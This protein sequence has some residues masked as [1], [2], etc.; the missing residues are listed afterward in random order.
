MKKFLREVILLLSCYLP[1]KLSQKWQ[2]AIRLTALLSLSD[3]ALRKL[4]L[5]IAAFTILSLSSVNSFAQQWTILGNES[6]ISSDASSYTSIAVLDNIPF[7]VYRDTGPVVKVK[8]RNTSTGAWEQLGDNIGAN[9]TYTRIYLDKTNN[10]YVTYVDAANGNKLA[11][12][13]YNA[14]T[15]IWEPLNSDPNQLYVSTGSVTSTVSQYSSTQRSSLAFD[16]D[17]NP[18]IAFGEGAEL[19]PYVKKFNGTSWVTVG[20]GSVDA[21]AKIV[22]PSLVIDEAD[23]QWLAFSSLSSAT[24]STGNLALY[25]FNRGTWEPVPSTVTSIR[26]TTMAFNSSG[27][28]TIAYF[29]TGNSNKATIIVYN[30]A[31]NTWSSATAL[32]SRD[33]P[34][35]NLIRDV[36]GNLY[37]SFVDAISTAFS[38]VARVF[39]QA[40]GSSTWTELRDPA[41]TRGIDEPTSALTIAAGTEN[42]YIVYTKS[43]SIAISTPIVRI[44]TPPAAPA[45][46]TTKALSAITTSS[47]VTAVDITSDG[48][49]PITERGVVYGTSANPT[50]ANSKIADLSGGTGSFN[51]SITGLAP[52]TL[53]YVRGYAINNGN[54]TYGNTLRLNTLAVPDAVVTTARQMEYLTRGLVA[55]RKTTSQVFVSWRMLGTDPSNIAFN[56]YRDDIKLNASPITTST[57]YLDNVPTN[58]VYIVKPVINGVEGAPSAPVSVWSKNQLSIPMQIPAGGTTFDGVAYTY[59]AND[60]SVGDVDGDGEYEIFVK[61]DPTKLNHNSGGYS[62][63]QIIDCYKLDGTRLWRINLGKNINAGP[64]FTQFMVYDLDGDGKAEMVCKTA[65]GTVDGTGVVIGNATV[66]YRNSNG[67]VQQGPEFL[68]VFNGLTGVAMA[69]TTYQPARGQVTDWGDN[70]GNRQDRFVSAIAYLDGARPSLI[71]GRGYYDKLVR[72]AYDWRNG[73][74]TLRWIFDSKDPNNPANEAYSGQGNHQ[75]TIGDVDGDGKDEVINGSSAINDDGKRLWTYGLG[76]GDALH[77]TDM[78]P[79]RP[80]QEIWINLESPGQYASLGLRQYDAKTGQTIWGV[81]TTGDVGRSLAA[82]IDPSRRGYEMW[83][84]S[85]NLYDVKGNEISTNKPSYNFGIWWDGDLARELLEGNVMDKW[86]YLTNS[87]GRLLTIYNDAPVSSNNDTK[88]TPCLTA[89]LMGDWREEMILRRSDNTALI[90]FTTNIL[91][92]HRIHTLMHDPQYRTAVAWQNSGYNQPPYPSFY[93]G[94]DMAA[95]PAPNIAIKAIVQQTI[96]FPVI[97]AKFVGDTDF[98]PGATAGSGLP[99]TYTSSDPIVATIV[100][101]HVHILSAGSTTITASQGGDAT[102]LAAT[103]L[104]QVLTVNKKSQTIIFSDLPQKTVGDADF[105]LSA[106]S[107]SGLAPSYSSSN[108]AVA[109]LTNGVVHI[110]GTGTT[111]ITAS[112]GGDAMYS[113]APLVE[114]ILIVVPAPSIFSLPAKNFKISATDETCSSSNN[115]KIKIEA[116]AAFNYKVKLNGSGTEYLLTSAAP[117]EIA[118]LTAG[119]YEVC[120]TVDGQAVYKFCAP[121]VRITEPATLSVYSSVNPADRT[122]YLSLSGGNSYEVELNGQIYKTGSNT[123]TLNLAEGKNDLVVR[124]D[125]ECQGIFTKSLILDS[126]KLIYPNPFNG[127][128]FI[129][130]GDD[131]SKTAKLSIFSLTGSEVYSKEHVLGSGD[132]ELNLSSLAPGTYILKIKTAQSESS[133]QIIKK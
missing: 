129:N 41:V 31:D 52:S 109:T 118:N 99:V 45:I 4:T 10:L 81:P 102:Y 35:L 70:Y 42:P 96:S 83:G 121:Q 87:M 106:T 117:L 93:I 47:A 38:N 28:P 22:A 114:Q 90:L 60:C 11:V 122:V 5:R 17:N 92:E 72:A 107:T 37:C 23:V 63:D 49:S 1:I 53:Y 14:A 40:A 13:I 69:T 94:Y 51:V 98:N 113:A 16:S 64:H 6:Q 119:N 56:L 80:G 44:Y 126:K 133:S 33:A 71:I 27:N 3:S 24:S 19:T 8:K 62:G 132:I 76:H 29:N 65:D 66:D 115:G 130:F 128:L 48:G 88:K 74:L 89:D 61:W 12:K 125:K 9:L 18:Y 50:T 25:K 43:N 26:H 15:Q 100:N 123:F 111:T 112:Q 32:S 54:T 104:T 34:H 7:A 108:T 120:I 57:N 68:T 110:V 101:G 116:T 55:V 58:G 85:G 20:T 91:T 131:L 124:T 86:N 97:G 103:P 73:Q 127:T 77:M 78:D 79:D 21:A 59:S 84:S 67:W 105:T 82:D 39:M 36:S 2:K 95:P 30:K 75:M 46:L